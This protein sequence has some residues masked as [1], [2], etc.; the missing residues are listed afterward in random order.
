[1][2]TKIYTAYRL[3]KSRDL[4][5]F[6]RDTRVKAI[7][8]IRKT[9]LA[10]EP[11]MEVDVESEDYRRWLKHLSPAGARNQVVARILRE[12]YRAQLGSPDRNFFNFDVN[13]G[14][15]EY[16][17]RL[18]LIPFCDSLMRDVLRFLR[19][20]PR[21][22]DFCYFNNTDR[23]RGISQAAWDAR[24][25]IWDAID[26]AGWHDHIVIDICSHSSYWTIDPFTLRRDHAFRK[27]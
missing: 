14:V 11:Q 24:G 4:W 5:P 19:R 22:E 12:G 20:D 7:N 23:P 2:S 21:L 8:N 10:L 6:V 3:R 18:Y 17:H 27:T 1:M 9:L 13:I 16:R 25:I 15:W 26:A